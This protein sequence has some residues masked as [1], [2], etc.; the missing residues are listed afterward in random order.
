MKEASPSLSAVDITLYISISYVIR[1]LSCHLDYVR[2]LSIKTTHIKVTAQNSGC[3]AN[4]N[5]SGFYFLKIPI[6]V[7]F[8]TSKYS[9]KRYLRHNPQ[10]YKESSISVVGILDKGMTI[11]MHPFVCW[12]SMI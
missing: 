3:V 1:N 2:S 12:M 10:Y 9:P 4:S 11:T 7:V 6:F 5:L 8:K